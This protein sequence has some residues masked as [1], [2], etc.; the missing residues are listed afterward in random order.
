MCVPSAFNSCLSPR[1]WG[2]SH[3]RTRRLAPA[4]QSR[5]RP[6]GELLPALCGARAAR[7]DGALGAP[8]LYRVTRKPARPIRRSG[9]HVTGT[10][11]APMP[12]PVKHLAQ[13]ISQRKKSRRGIPRRLWSAIA[14]CYFA[15][16]SVEVLPPSWVAMSTAEP[17]FSLSL[18]TIFEAR[19]TAMVR[20]FA[21]ASTTPFLVIRV[22]VARSD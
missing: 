17:S 19:L 1:P 12:P 16:M 5:P 9:L 2:K 18:E 20:P 4:V 8:S 15:A 3:L 14:R 22:T 7:R 10:I 6:I 11:I 21:N 13:E